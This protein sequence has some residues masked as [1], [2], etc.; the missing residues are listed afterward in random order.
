MRRASL[1]ITCALAVLIPA[2]LPAHVA[3]T[4]PDDEL[5]QIEKKIDRRREKI[6]EA[7]EQRRGLLD[8]L[9]ESDRQRV[10]LTGTIEE[11]EAALAESNAR[12][13]DVRGLLALTRGEL[14]IWTRRLDETQAELDR[15]QAILDAHAAAAYKLG[16]VGLLGMVLE[17]D[18]LRSLT[19]RVSFMES[20]IGSD[21]FVVRGVTESRDQ[22]GLQQGQID[23]F[24]GDVTTRRN[25]IREQLRRIARLKAEKEAIRLEVEAAIAEREATLEDVESTR[26]RYVRAV[27]ELEAESARISGAIQAGGSSGSGSYD[28]ELFYPTA[29]PIVS[30][31]GWRIHPIYGTPRFHSGVD[32]DGECDQPIWAAEDGTVISAGWNGGY[33]Q[34]TVIDHGNGLSTLYAHQDAFAVSSGESVR[35]GEVIGYVGT[36]GW[37]TGCHLHFEVRINGEPVDP[38]PYLT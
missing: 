27:E 18:D 2:G 8:A 31:F 20:V 6:R 35:R 28:G 9:E 30:G 23:D 7:G 22:V 13:T 29:G 11:L 5:E 10:E 12:L 21:A 37:S 26:A 16:P 33:G 34:A 15:R 38:E 4:G 24:E 14:R 32:I 25:E 1:A 19:D 17:S 3:A 36:T